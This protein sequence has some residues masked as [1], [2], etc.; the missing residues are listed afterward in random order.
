MPPD[1]LADADERI[2]AGP[3]DHRGHA[4]IELA[5]RQPALR[6]IG[7]HQRLAAPQR[8]A[9]QVVERQGQRVQVEVVGVVHQ[10]RVV[11]AV[12][13]LEPHG[14]RRRG[15]ETRRR[16][17]HRRTE[18]LDQLGVA[19]RRGIA[20]R[21]LRHL[22]EARRIDR[23]AV[24]ETRCDHRRQRFVVAVVDDPAGPARQQQ[25]LLAL[26]GQ[27]DEILLVGV[28]DR[29]EDH[30][31]RT[32]DP[33]EPL[34]LARFRDPGLEDGQLLVALEHQHR[35]RH[36]QLRIEALG[37]AVALRPCGQ[38]LGDPLLDDRLAVRPGDGRH[39][40]RETGAVG[41]GETLQGVDGI[42]RTHEPAVGHRSGR[43]FALDQEGPHAAVIHLG[44]EVVR[45]V[46]GAPHGHKQRRIAQ[47]AAE[48]TAVGHDRPHAA[49]PPREFAADEG[50]DL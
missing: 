42:V 40:P 29:G 23:I 24:G 14:Q 13:H 44:D 19:A 32:D 7:E 15:G 9:V 27:I 11:D 18:R 39:A 28:A 26:L 45:V 20:D 8:H 22:G 41:G 1:P 5:V 16:V 12:L 34:H 4:R 38:L 3:R 36:A 46:V 35:E 17:A 30:H 6:N 31:V 47:L 37:R 2:D 10:N 48:R 33:F 50:G 49:V 21:L 43:R 25:L